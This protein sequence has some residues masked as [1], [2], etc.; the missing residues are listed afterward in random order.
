MKTSCN[1]NCCSEVPMLCVLSSVWDL[2]CMDWSLESALGDPPFG[3]KCTENIYSKSGF[4]SADC[5]PSASSEPC[6]VLLYGDW[7]SPLSLHHKEQSLFVES[8]VLAF[9]VAYIFGHQ[10]FKYM[11]GETVHVF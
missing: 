6:S 5:F 10:L 2:V 7:L 11:T 3:E 8:N 9:S 4:G 1:K